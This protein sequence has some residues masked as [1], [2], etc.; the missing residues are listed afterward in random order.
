MNYFKRDYFFKKPKVNGCGMNL[1]Y[2]YKNIT[3]NIYIPSLAIN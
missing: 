2:F 1:K 3:F